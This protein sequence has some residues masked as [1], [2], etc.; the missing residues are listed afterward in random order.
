NLGASAT[1]GKIAGPIGRSVIRA[2]LQGGG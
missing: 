1:G 2:G